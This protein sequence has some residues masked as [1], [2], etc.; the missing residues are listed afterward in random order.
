MRKRLFEVIS[1][2]TMI[3]YSTQIDVLTPFYGMG[4]DIHTYDPFSILTD[5]AL[6]LS[7]FGFKFSKN[8]TTPDKKY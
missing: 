2:L 1:M 4:I 3:G 7:A 5:P 8:V 6:K